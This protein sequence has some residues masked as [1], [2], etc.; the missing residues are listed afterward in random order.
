MLY[1]LFGTREEMQAAYELLRLAAQIEPDTGNCE[2]E[3]T[4][5]AEDGYTIGSV[6]TGR[7]LCVTAG[8]PVIHW[9]DDRFNILAQV[10]SPLS[11]YDRLLDFWA[12]EAGPI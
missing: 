10:S 12:N 6:S 9:T 5:P 4:W 8:F 7:Y 2:D 1:T 3:T 11:D